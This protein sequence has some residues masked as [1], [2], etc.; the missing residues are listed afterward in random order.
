MSE[1]NH[2]KIL[3]LCEMMWQITLDTC[4]HDI[5]RLNADVDIMHGKKFD[6]NNF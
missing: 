3:L 2:F 5:T 4:L 1:I 6:L